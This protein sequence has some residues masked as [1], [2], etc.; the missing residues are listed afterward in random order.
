MTA[1]GLRLNIKSNVY[2]SMESVYTILFIGCLGESLYMD[3]LHAQPLQPS[4]QR[5]SMNGSSL[6]RISLAIRTNRSWIGSY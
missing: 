1:H 6:Y 3:T 5:I 4:I 2:T